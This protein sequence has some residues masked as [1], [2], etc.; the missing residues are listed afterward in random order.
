MLLPLLVLS[1]EV[2]KVVTEI[3]EEPVAFSFKVEV[4]RAKRIQVRDKGKNNE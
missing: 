2:L 1:D 4:C 3:S